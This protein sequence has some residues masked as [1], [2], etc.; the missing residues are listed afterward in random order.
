MKLINFASGECVGKICTKCGEEKELTQFSINSS[1]KNCLNSRCKQCMNLL[2]KN[3]RDTHKTEIE[4]RTN[5]YC[6]HRKRAVGTMSNHK[7]RGYT[8][9]ISLESLETLFKVTKKCPICGCELTYNKRTKVS[10]SN[11]PS[12]DRKNNDT[13]LDE[14]NLWVICKKCNSTKQDRTF[15]EFIEYCGM[16]FNKFKDLK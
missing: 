8:I 3:Y 11:S 15:D 13:I 16:V 2:N 10:K 4:T 6:I 14:D 5:N 7:L 12:L 9:N 1:S